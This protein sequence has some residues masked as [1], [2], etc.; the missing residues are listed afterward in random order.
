M[1]NGPSYKHDVTNSN[2]NIVG[3]VQYKYTNKVTKNTL[4]GMYR[5]IQR[6]TSLPL[7]VLGS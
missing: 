6:Q 4:I 3:D 2:N 7:H 5:N 1:Q